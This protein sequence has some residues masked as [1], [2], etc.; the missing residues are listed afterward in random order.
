MSGVVIEA[1]GQVRKDVDAM[2][3]RYQGLVETMREDLMAIG[4]VVTGTRI[5][6]GEILD[7]LNILY[8]Y[9][10]DKGFEKGED[11]Y[12]C[13]AALHRWTKYLACD[14]RYR[15][16]KASK[17]DRFK[18]IYRNNYKFRRRWVGLLSGI[19][20]YAELMHGG[21]TF[22]EPADAIRAELAKLTRGYSWWDGFDWAAVKGHIDTA[23]QEIAKESTAAPMGL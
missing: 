22:R 7:G 4:R 1:R 18:R 21:A 12:Q 5:K 11:T 19:V 16:A 20:K 13:C 3:R 15:K 14:D 2:Y 6:D 23:K 10:N 9:M 17:D 8:H